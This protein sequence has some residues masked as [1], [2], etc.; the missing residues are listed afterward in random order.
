M[1]RVNHQ[2][3]QDLP[4]MKITSVPIGLEAADDVALCNESLPEE[5]AYAIPPKSLRGVGLW[6]LCCDPCPGLSAGSSVHDSCA[7]CKRPQ[8]KKGIKIVLFSMSIT[9]AFFA[10]AGLVP[11]NEDMAI[12]S[13]NSGLLLLLSDLILAGNTMFPLFLRLLVWFLGRLTKVKEL[14]PMIKNPEEMHFGNFLGRSPTVFLFST[15]VALSAL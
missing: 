10:N 14:W 9:G 13:K 2:D 15:V 6:V 5:A 3:N 8:N 1:L 12:F 11:T 7:N 4:S